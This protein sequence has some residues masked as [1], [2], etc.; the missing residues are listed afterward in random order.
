VKFKRL[1]ELT[2]LIESLSDS[3]F[4]MTEAVKLA[5][6]LQDIFKK[7]DL[8]VPDDVPDVQEVKLKDKDLLKVFDGRKEQDLKMGKVLLKLFPNLDEPTFHR[9]I[10][11]IKAESTDDIEFTVEKDVVKA[12][13]TYCIDSCMSNKKNLLYFYTTQPD[14][15]IVIA[16]K[17]GKPIGRALLWSKVEGAKNGMFMDRIYPADDDMIVAKFHKY[18]E[19]KGWSHR[20]SQRT[21][22]T[23]ENVTI[24]YNVQNKEKLIG[25]LL[26]YMDTFRYGQRDIPKLS[27]TY[28]P[29][30]Q[31]SLIVFSSTDGKILF[32]IAKELKELNNKFIVAAR[33]GHLEIVKELLAAGADVHAEDDAAL[34]RAAHNGH[35]E[36]VKELLA[37]GADVHA[38]DDAALRRAAEYGRLEVVK[39]LLSAGADVHAWD[40]CALRWAARNGHL[41]VVKDLLAAGANVHADDD[42]ALSWA[43]ECGHLEVVKELLAAGANVHGKNDFALRWAAGNGY[44]DIVKELLAAGADAT[45]LSPDLQK[46]LT[47]K[48]K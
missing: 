24:I 25:K 6:E 43:A 15:S 20:L 8:K 32:D 30:D 26:P 17:D 38:E 16:R 19:E 45:K 28:K 12:Y 35:L 5:Q 23:D 33:G 2:L 14:I 18:A 34:R 37:A 27:N 22:N 41:E 4:L 36:I 47:D 46:K 21:Y 31:Q 3:G 7:F 44:L 1:A 13:T 39:E 40:D 11:E 48:G 10:G 29:F 42:Y 9:I